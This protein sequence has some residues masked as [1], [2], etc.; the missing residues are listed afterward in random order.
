LIFFY[1]FILYIYIYSYICIHKYTHI[2]IYIN[3]ISKSLRHNEECNKTLQNTTKLEQC[4]ARISECEA[5]IDALKIKV[6]E[7]D[8]NG[9][10]LSSVIHQHERTI[11]D[12]KITLENETQS[13]SIASEKIKMLIQDTGNIK[14]IAHVERKQLEDELK[15]EIQRIKAE[16]DKVKESYEL[17]DASNER[18]MSAL[19]THL[20]ALERRV[21]DL[22]K[23]KED[24]ERRGLS[25]HKRGLELEEVLESTTA[26]RDSALTT[27][28]KSV[29]KIKEMEKELVVLKTE[30]DGKAKH[31]LMVEEELSQLKSQGIL[32]AN[33]ITYISQEYQQEKSNNIGREL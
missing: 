1:I 9:T 21:E 25:L 19:R 14:T 30:C 7:G 13:L 33:E 2:Y 31:I 10:K 6:V 23:E 22:V 12:L 16:R 26:E 24:S 32:M 11:H 29:E 28:N 18:E 27:I 8:A 3:I 5:V 4:K 20:C 15:K 17:H